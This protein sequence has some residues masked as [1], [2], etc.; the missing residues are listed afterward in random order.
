MLTRIKIVA[1]L[2]LTYKMIHLILHTWDITHFESFQPRK[3][4]NRTQR[5]ADA[6]NLRMRLQNG[7]IRLE[8]W[9]HVDRR[10]TF[11]HLVI[12]QEH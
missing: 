6:Q 11:R 12:L 1:G 4:R 2:A 7:T 8:H 3:V 5:T 9:V 10:V